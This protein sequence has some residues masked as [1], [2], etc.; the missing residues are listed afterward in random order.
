MNA[1]TETVKSKLTQVKNEVQQL[2]DELRVK[3]N[4]AS[5]DVRDTWS[6]L[7]PQVLE[8]VGKAQQAAQKANEDA[9]RKGAELRDRLRGLLHKA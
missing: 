8:Y 4:L 5:K 7:E 6:H 2:A 9:H 1:E 3:V